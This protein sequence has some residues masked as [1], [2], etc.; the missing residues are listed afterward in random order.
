MAQNSMAQLTQGW[1]RFFGFTVARGWLA[2]NPMT[3]VGVIQHPRTSTESFTF[4]EIL[5]LLEFRENP[6]LDNWYYLALVCYRLDS[7]N[8]IS[9]ATSVRVEDV[10][11]STGSV[12][13]A[14]AKDDVPGVVYLTRLLWSFC[15]ITSTTSGRTSGAVVGCSPIFVA[16]R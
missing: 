8:R 16:T 3:R 14:D 9:E 7:G 6:S 13:M 15:A 5:R 10:D 2:Y 1:R 12:K 11:W 4:D